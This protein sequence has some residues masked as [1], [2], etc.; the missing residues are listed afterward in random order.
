MTREWLQLT[1]KTKAKNW[2]NRCNTPNNFKVVPKVDKQVVDLQEWLRCL[3]DLLRE[4][5]LSA[6]GAILD[7]NRTQKMK[8]F[9]RKM[10]LL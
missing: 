8:M 9:S 1:I 10:E 6:I 7:L 4:V 3:R 5:K 2:A